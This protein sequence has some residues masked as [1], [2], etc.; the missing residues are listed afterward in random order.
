M[1][2]RCGSCEAGAQTLQGC[3]LTTV[4]K[5]FVQELVLTSQHLTP[6]M[7]DA[8][9]QTGQRHCTLQAG[10]VSLKHVETALINPPASILEP[11][12]LQLNLYCEDL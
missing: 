2:P 12:C 3:V 1:M 7:A 10:W 4:G 8:E 9:R 11:S 5:F 6:V